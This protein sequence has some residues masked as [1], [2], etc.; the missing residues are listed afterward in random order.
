MEVRGEVVVEVG[1]TF[2]GLHLLSAT[3]AEREKERVTSDLEIT[4]LFV[5]YRKMGGNVYWLYC[6][7]LCFDMNEMLVIFFVKDMYVS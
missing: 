1:M 6:R 4:R 5:G 7:G 3:S 2:K